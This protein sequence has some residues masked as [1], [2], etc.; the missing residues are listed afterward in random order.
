MAQP[1]QGPAR[2]LCAPCCAHTPTLQVI[3]TV[4]YEHA[5][6]SFL[7]DLAAFTLPVIL[8]Q[9]PAQP[10]AGAAGSDDGAATTAQ[11][12]PAGERAGDAPAGSAAGGGGKDAGGGSRGNSGDGGSAGGSDDGGGG[13]GTLPALPVESLLPAL[14]DR[15]SREVVSLQTLNDANRYDWQGVPAD[16]G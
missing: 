4:G 13:C 9:P 3:S 12:G 8:G 14:V 16:V 5:L 6:R 7:R 2:L 10:S 15:L 11:A 1:L